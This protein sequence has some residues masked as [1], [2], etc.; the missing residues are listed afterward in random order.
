M[1]T[2]NPTQ[3]NLPIAPQSV[4]P[5]PDTLRNIKVD[6]KI[7]SDV[8]NELVGDNKNLAHAKFYESLQTLSSESPMIIGKYI[9]KY[10]NSI[11]N[12]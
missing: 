2:N 5:A 8:V 6:P 12:F 10:A 7:N 4:P 11:K 1:V 9:S 3:L